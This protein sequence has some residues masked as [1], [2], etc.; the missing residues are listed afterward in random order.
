[1]M[2]AKS[3]QKG[4]DL[5]ELLRAYF[6]RAGVYAVR[7]VP[8]K[9][10]GDD[11]TDV[12]LWLY[13]RPTG[14]S[15]RRQIVD[16]KSKNKPKAVERLFWTKG[17]S[18]LLEVDGAY[19]AT[20]DTR[21]LLKEMSRRIGISVLDG[22]DLKR[23]ADSEKVLFQNRLPEEAFQEKVKEVD[24]SRRSKELQSSHSDLKAAL[25]D[26]FGSG[27]VNRALEH[28][29]GFGQSLSASHPN[30][31]GAEAALRLLYLAVSICAI[32]LD[33][34]LTKVSF[35]SS[36]ERRKMLLNVIRYGEESEDRGLEK[37][38]IAT[39]LIERYAQNGRALA[40]T[41]AQSI[42]D[43]YSKIPAEIIADF[44]LKN[45]KAGGLFS[46][47]RML[48]MRAYSREL[49]GYDDLSPEEKSIVGALLDFAGLDRTSIA[50]AW[51]SSREAIETL[52]KADT[53][54]SHEIGPLF[55]S[56]KDDEKRS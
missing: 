13:E 17:L 12:D 3:G 38:R 11:L 25:I 5:E 41:V 6:I 35:K 9:L 48:E 22:A 37:V 31:L 29:F 55:D 28:V 51:E 24:K 42:R 16:A 46:L 44:V 7:G 4:Y 56:W 8:L 23:M 49:L 2:T 45:L 32:S 14:S 21:P 18:E 39:A 26:N 19:I 52:N 10:E 43:E 27:T 36:D 30:S 15:R 34:S 33:Y 1:M 20:T 53:E 54:E 50:K 40:H 47:A